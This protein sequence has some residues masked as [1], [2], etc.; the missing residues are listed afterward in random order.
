MHKFLSAS[1][2]GVVPRYRV[3][4]NYACHFPRKSE[5]FLKLALVF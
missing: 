3:T 1:K 5:V 2:D 4:Q